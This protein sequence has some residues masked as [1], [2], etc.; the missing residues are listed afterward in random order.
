M[1]F[2]MIELPILPS[3]RGADH[4]YP[5]R[6]HDPVIC[7]DDHFL[8][9]PVA[10]HRRLEVQHHAY[11]GRRGAV[12]VANGIEVELRDFGKSATSC[13]TLP[14]MVARDS[15]STGCAPRIPRSISA[16][17]MPSSIDSASARVAA[18]DGT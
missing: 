13:E 5:V 16:A 3:R 14:I 15:R 1:R 10:H 12:G 18:P 8:A 7:R 4:R 2:F 6:L 11:V 17:A 9:R